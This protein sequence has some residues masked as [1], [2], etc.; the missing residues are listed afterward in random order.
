MRNIFLCSPGVGL[1]ERGSDDQDMALSPSYA[2]SFKYSYIF[3]RKL[4]FD[5]FSDEIE[6]ITHKSFLYLW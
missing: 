1:L 6:L 3:I 5:L 4:W 2:L